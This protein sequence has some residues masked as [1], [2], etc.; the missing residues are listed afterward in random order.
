MYQLELHPKG[1]NSQDFQSPSSKLTGLM[2]HDFLGF[3]IPCKHNK[4]KHGS[5]KMS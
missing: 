1:K 5:Y 4:I 3:M 2:L